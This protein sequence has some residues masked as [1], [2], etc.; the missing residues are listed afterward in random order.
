M[1]NDKLATELLREVKASAKRWFVAFC[2]MVGLEIVTIAG[3]MWYISLPVDETTTSY[4][5]SVDD[6]DNSNVS[7]RIGDY[8]GEST[9]ESNQNES[10]ESST[11]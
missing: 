9:T 10:T 6:I 7:Q 11:P 8:N 2:I 5:Q 1:D 4:E 3:F